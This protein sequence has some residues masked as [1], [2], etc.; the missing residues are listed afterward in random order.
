MKLFAF[1][2]IAAL[3]APAAWA[4]NGSGS[5]LQ[6]GVNSHWVSELQTYLHANQRAD[7]YNEGPDGAFG[8]LTTAG[9]RSWQ[10]VAGYAVTGRVSVGSRQWNQLKREATASRLPGYLDKRSIDAATQNGWSIDASQSPGMVTVLHYE[11]KLGQVVQTLSIPA[12][13]GGWIKGKRYYTRNGVFR[14]H[15]VYGID[16]WSTTY[17]APMRWAAC[18]DGGRC[19]HFDGLGPSHGCV[20]IPS[21]AAA[22]YIHDRPLRTVVVVHD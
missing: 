5:V 8:P 2:F 1:L 7:F 21:M 17:N 20:H 22:K 4:G 13:Y 11:P 9:L 12:S 19:F 18:F 10:K 15:D 14:I 3:M 16:F 6:R